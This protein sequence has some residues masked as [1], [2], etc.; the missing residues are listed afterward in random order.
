VR[1]CS[2]WLLVSGHILSGLHI[3]TAVW[4]KIIQNDVIIDII[5]NK[6]SWT[7]RTLYIEMAMGTRN[8][9]T[10]RVLPDMKAGTG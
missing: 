1:D 7:L 6:L 4:A 5:D 10:R 3:K 9:N 8:P 2:N